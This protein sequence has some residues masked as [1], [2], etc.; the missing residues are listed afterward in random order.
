[1]HSII[2]RAFQGVGGGGSY[3]VGS[4]MLLQ[5]VPANQITRL[6]SYTGVAFILATVLGPVIGGAISQ[7]TTWRWV[8]LFNVPVGAFGLA[9]A[10]LGIPNGYPH[11]AS[12]A[13]KL[14]KVT[15]ST[16]T[17]RVDFIGCGLL[18]CATLAFTSAFQ[19]VNTKF[20]WNSAYFIVLIIVSVLLAVF[21]LMWERYLTLRQGQ[22]EPVLPWRFIVR[23]EMLGAML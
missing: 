18:L 23:R 2:F 20:S 1:L 10:F 12:S 7:N 22:R 11:H 21:L 6:A 9:L 14:P 15:L 19:E 17:A 3:A 13:N 8:F 5:I 4:I 16:V